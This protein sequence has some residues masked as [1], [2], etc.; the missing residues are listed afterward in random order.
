MPMQHRR[1]LLLK[2]HE[3]GMTGGD[4]VFY[5]MDI[6]PQDDILNSMQTWQGNDGR[7][8]AAKQAFESVFHVVI[9]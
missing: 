8:A 9:L 7:D 2:A 4:Y 3:K 5:T 1:K 6:L